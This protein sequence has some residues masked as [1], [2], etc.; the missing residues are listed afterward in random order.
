MTLQTHL[1][2]GTGRDDAPILPA[3]RRRPVSR[4]AAIP[5][6]LMECDARYRALCRL[7]VLDDR[8]LRDIGLTRDAVRA[9]VAGRR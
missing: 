9:A 1:T 6:A 4:L 7:G 5:T 3:A 2:A 8:M